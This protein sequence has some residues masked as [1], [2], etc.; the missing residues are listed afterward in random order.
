MSKPWLLLLPALLAPACADLDV[1]ED[2]SAVYSAPEE[3]GVLSF[4]NGPSATFAVLDVDVGLDR[5]AA[6]NIVDH[7]QADAL[8]TVA[9][10]DA[11]AYVGQSA[12]D[13]LLAYC[14]DH[15][16]VPD[17]LVEGVPFSIEQAA[18]VVAVAN[19]ATQ[20]ELDDTARL[21]SRAAANIVAARPIADLDHLATVS[22]VGGNALTKLQTFAATWSG[23][24]APCT[25]F[26]LTGRSDADAG[27]WTTMLE[28]ATWGDFGPYGRVWGLQ[29]SCFDLTTDAGRGELSVAIQRQITWSSSAF[30]RVGG[31]AT[32]GAR[33]ESL[34][35]WT[36]DAVDERV[37][38]GRWVPGDDATWAQ[39]EA[40]VERVVGPAR[41]SPADFMEIAL[42]TD[43]E[44]CSEHAAARI[45][46][47]DGSIVVV[48]V[49]PRC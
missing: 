8:D 20:V 28:E 37:A 30:V 12:M 31:F 5:R 33:F 15:D 48:Q 26:S 46:T 4:L 45:D 7:V 42:S 9:E 22:Y 17:L 27:A 3:Y 19:G 39:R 24:T 21:D 25:S 13:K 36:Y 6:Q 43:A 34:F 18:Q 47:R 23:G 35:Y 1:A 44:E 38:D 11:I 16:L 2:A 32:G 40:I 10:L 29:A 41:T 14:A 49:L